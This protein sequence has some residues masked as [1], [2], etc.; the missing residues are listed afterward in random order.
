MKLEENYGCPGCAD[1]PIYVAVV[2]HAGQFK[3]SH[4]FDPLGPEELPQ[5]LRDASALIDSVSSALE[6]CE[7]TPF[8][9]VAADCA[10]VRSQDEGH[11]TGRP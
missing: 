4:S 6:R 7:S 5:P 1:G 3:S 8:V 2:H 10:R 9:Q 11:S